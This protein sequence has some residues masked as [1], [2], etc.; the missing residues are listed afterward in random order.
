[1]S[2]IFV[3]ETKPGQYHNSGGSIN[4]KDQNFVIFRKEDTPSILIEK[5]SG[6]I[7]IRAKDG[8]SLVK[9]DAEEKKFFFGNND[10]AKIFSE[11][12]ELKIAYNKALKKLDLFSSSLDSLG[13][14]VG[15]LKE[16][17]YSFTIKKK[18]QRLTL[19]GKVG[20][21]TG[22]ATD[23]FPVKLTCTT[24]RRNTDNKVVGFQILGFFNFT[25]ADSNS[26]DPVTP[27][28]KFY[29][30][31]KYPNISGII[32]FY[33]TGIEYGKH[34]PIKGIEIKQSY[35]TIDPYHFFV[36]EFGKFEINVE[37]NF[38]E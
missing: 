18:E 24:K 22:H 2:K 27:A 31:A 21:G 38:E 14:D 23:I 3:N 17:T 16:N 35:L 13:H 8:S 32:D 30:R 26:P 10:L 9:I 7:D 6:N 28:N 29:T 11:F 4:N 33:G 37:Y 36:D 12:G 19:G 34:K 20:R 1:M 5:E 15:S 25:R